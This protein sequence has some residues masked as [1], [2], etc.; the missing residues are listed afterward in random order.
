[1]NVRKYICSSYHPRRPMLVHDLFD[2]VFIE[3]G[4]QSRDSTRLRKFS[5]KG[6]LNAGHP[7]AAR[8][9]VAEQCAVVRSDVHNQ[10]IVRQFN[11]R[12]NF[13]IK[14]SEVL[15]ENAGRSA[16]IGIFGRKQDIWLH[17]KSQL[18]E[19]AGSTITNLSGDPQY[20]FLTVSPGPHPYFS[21]K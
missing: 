14:L 9:V 4:C 3:I 20:L 5:G 13:A 11:F 19:M 16:G 18:H 2:A 12:A 1:M 7:M 8:L 6:W 15:A 21:L 10:I 17:G